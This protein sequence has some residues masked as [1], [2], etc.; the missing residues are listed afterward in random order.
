[1]RPIVLREYLYVFDSTITHPDESIGDRQ[2]R[3]VV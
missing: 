2:R 3:L 1:L